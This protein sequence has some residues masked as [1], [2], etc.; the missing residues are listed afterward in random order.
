MSIGWETPGIGGAEGFVYPPSKCFSG[1]TPEGWR[2]ITTQ[3]V[4]QE[5]IFWLK[6]K[7]FQGTLERED[8]PDDFFGFEDEFDA[9]SPYTKDSTIRIG[10]AIVEENYLELQNA[11]LNIRFVYNRGLKLYVGKVRLSITKGMLEA[12]LQDPQNNMFVEEYDEALR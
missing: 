4:G 5:R 7:I 2:S 12:A 3:D 1:K 8:I 9:N 10:I 6:G 11:Y